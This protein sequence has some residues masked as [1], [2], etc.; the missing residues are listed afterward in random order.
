MR[1]FALLPALIPLAIV[2]AC[3]QQTQPQADSPSKQPGNMK[4]LPGQ[5]AT[6]PAFNYASGTTGTY[7]VPHGNYVTSIWAHNTTGGGTVTITPSSPY[8]N[9]ACNNPAIDAG[10]YDSGCGGDAACD[11]AVPPNYYPVCNS[12][13][14]T[15]TVPALTAYWLPIPVLQGSAHELADGTTLVFASTD[16]YVVTMLQYGP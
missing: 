8:A 4:L 6:A 10:P 13:G 16:A 7:V 15:I 3:A 1:A 14:S 9:P 11:A 2:V 12:V 5:T